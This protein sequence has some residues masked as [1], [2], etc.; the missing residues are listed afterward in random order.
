MDMVKRHSSARDVALI[1]GVI[2]GTAYFMFS[3][4]VV[5]FIQSVVFV[6]IRLF[7]FIG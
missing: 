7:G 3:E 2:S 5:G 1:L 6:I 4:G